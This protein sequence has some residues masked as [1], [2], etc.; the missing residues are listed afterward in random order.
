VKSYLSRGNNPSVISFVNRARSCMCKLHS[1][2]HLISLHGGIMRVRTC[3][4]SLS[5]WRIVRRRRTDVQQSTSVICTFA[6]RS[7]NITR[8]IAAISSLS[9]PPLF[10]SLCLSI[11]LS[12]CLSVSSRTVP[13]NA[14]VRSLRGCDRD[15]HRHNAGIAGLPQNRAR[16][17]AEMARLEKEKKKRKKKRKKRKQRKAERRNAPADRGDREC[18]INSWPFRRP[19][20]AR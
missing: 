9:L 13:R 12:V 5:L 8:F 18:A 4:A 7:R 17:R 6:Q 11:C 3:V 16:R 2:L 1:S 19:R 10:L 15:R 20:A 14:P